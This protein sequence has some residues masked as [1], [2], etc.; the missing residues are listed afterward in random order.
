[1]V[2]TAI[3]AAPRTMLAAE[4][5]VDCFFAGTALRV[6]LARAAT[7]FLAALL[8]VT[9]LGNARLV[10]LRFAAGRFDALDFFAA[11]FFFAFFLAILSSLGCKRQAS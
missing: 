1:M 6:A 5:R 9:R 3:A 2:A 10:P 11:D 8:F 7:T 4:V